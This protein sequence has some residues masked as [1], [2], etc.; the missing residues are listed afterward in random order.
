MKQSNRTEDLI[1]LEKVETQAMEKEEKAPYDK[2][3]TMAFLFGDMSEEEF[4]QRKKENLQKS[5]EKIVK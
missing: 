2:E 3:L 5:K 4:L 1:A